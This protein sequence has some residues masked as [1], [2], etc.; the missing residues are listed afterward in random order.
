[1]TATFS[2]LTSLAERGMAYVVQNKRPE[3]FSMSSTVG[4]AAILHTQ[5]SRA[6]S[7]EHIHQSQGIFNIVNTGWL[8]WEGK[9]IIVIALSTGVLTYGMAMG[10]AALLALGI[11]LPLLLNKRFTPACEEESWALIPREDRDTIRLSWE[12]PSGQKYAQYLYAFRLVANL[13]LA[14]LSG[15]YQLYFVAN[16]LAMTYTL[17]KTSK[18]AWLKFSKSFPID[19]GDLHAGR[20]VTFHY[21][22]ILLP[23]KSENK[24]CSICLEVERQAEGEEVEGDEQE[25]Q[26][27]GL[28]RRV[29]VYFCKAHAYHMACLMQ[30]IN[31]KSRAFIDGTFFTFTD[32]SYNGLPTGRSCNISMP[33]ANLLSCPE[34][35][36]Y[37]NHAFLSAEVEGCNQGASISLQNTTAK[38]T[39]WTSGFVEQ[40][41]ASYSAFQS[42]LS[43]LIHARP[44]LIADIIA[45]QDILLI[46]DAAA[47]L[48]DWIALKEQLDYEVRF[49]RVSAEL[50]TEIYF[51]MFLFAV[52][53]GIFIIA[54]NRLYKPAADLKGLLIKQ[55]SLS[56]QEQ[57]LISIGWDRP[58]LAMV[59]QWIYL[60][61]I[62][63]NLTA[64]YFSPKPV[65]KVLSAALQTLSLIH[66]S[67]L[68]WIRVDQKIA[69]DIFRDLTEADVTFYF[70]PPS[71]AAFSKEKLQPIVQ[72]I[73][74]YASTFFQGSSWYGCWDD[75]YVGFIRVSRNLRYTVSLAKGPLIKALPYF[76][77][78]SGT[79]Y[80]QF[81]KATAKL[82]F[83]GSR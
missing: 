14:Y 36:D 58:P 81:L 37:P 16:A 68:A 67:R 12:R 59:A 72:A 48:R 43:W 75:T 17:V 73:Y 11:A 13:A 62:A 38:L 34:C 74:Q 6:D 70:L 64:A 10:G 49:N 78:A 4:Q 24:Q 55:I 51:K 18:L 19:F 22:C 15:S 23:F 77:N 40:L 65:L 20:T 41:S 46:S 31:H 32:H 9:E 25:E 44:D 69:K 2:S 57:E 53:A 80:N 71:A 26:I 45:M 35:R 60:S 28:A 83:L 66:V 29:D 61:R 8:F 3:W 63:A 7:A 1:M 30:N 54:L 21:H 79:A 50:K 52:A 47:L 82:S 5:L 76:Y 33:E 27:E 42:S 39:A 56:P